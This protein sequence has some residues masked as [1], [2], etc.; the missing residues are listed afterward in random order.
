[1]LKSLNTAATGMAAQQSNMDVIANNIA[2]VSTTGFKKSRAE[3]EC[4]KLSVNPV[5]PAAQIHFRQTGCRW[6]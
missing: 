2:N 6:V 1:M 5:V 3:F 4:I